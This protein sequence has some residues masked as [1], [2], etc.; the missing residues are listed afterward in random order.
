MLIFV[1]FTK[2]TGIAVLI[3][4]LAK[5]CLINVKQFGF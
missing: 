3:F 2:L 5:P 4:C 1:C